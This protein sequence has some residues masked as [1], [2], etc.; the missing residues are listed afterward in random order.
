MVAEEIRRREEQPSKN[1]KL[2]ALKEQVQTK[3]NS[4]LKSPQQL[5][6]L[7][8]EIEYEEHKQRKVLEKANSKAAPGKGKA[9]APPPVFANVP[10][11][12]QRVG[13]M[14]KT[15]QVV[16]AVPPA[17][18]AQQ[19]M[20]PPAVVEAE[21]KMAAPPAKDI[22]EA[23]SEEVS[24]TTVLLV[25][26]NAAPCT[27]NV[28]KP[29]KKQAFAMTLWAD[30]PEITPCSRFGRQSFIMKEYNHAADRGATEC[31]CSYCTNSVR[32][33]ME[34]H[35]THLK[36]HEKFR[37]FFSLRKKMYPTL[38]DMD[39]TQ[40]W[41]LQQ[42][43]D[44]LTSL[45]RLWKQVDSDAPWFLS[46]QCVLQESQEAATRAVALATAAANK[47]TLK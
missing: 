17:A 40:T 43:N 4:D 41:T 10:K 46:R 26:L 36:W 45:V 29:K 32:N 16:V 30:G 31:G 24:V 42:Q 19:K 2:V 13:Q 3:I 18:E 9:P 6:R 44:M 20:V 5:K 12:K 23:P 7:A 39:S 15:K 27:G 14:S 47:K 11:T 21:Q 25:F 35:A 37:K 34:E 1:Q 8:A 33:T 22:A 38:K 28:P